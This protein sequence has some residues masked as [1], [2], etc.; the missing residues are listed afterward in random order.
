MSHPMLVD[1]LRL[2]ADRPGII[3]ADLAAAL[4]VTDKR[5]HRWVVKAEDADWIR[6]PR[7]MDG[8]RPLHL[9]PAGKQHLAC[10]K[11]VDRV[12]TAGGVL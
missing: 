2:I 5:I 12:V 4:K 11:P 7:R 3:A 10:A 9:T 1:I 8:T 6:R